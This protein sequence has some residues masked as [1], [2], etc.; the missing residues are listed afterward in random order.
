MATRTHASR[1]Q[2]PLTARASLDAELQHL[3][4]LVALRSILARHGSAADE[5]RRCDAEINRHRR[6]LALLAGQPSEQRQ[7]AA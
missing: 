5:L 2:P 1:F 7:T 3:R 4:D 6:E